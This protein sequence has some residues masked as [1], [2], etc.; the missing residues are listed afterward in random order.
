MKISSTFIREFFAL[1]NCK[2]VF[3]LALYYI[4]LVSILWISVVIYPCKLITKIKTIRMN[5][6][7]KSERKTCCFID[8]ECMVNLRKLLDSIKVNSEGWREGVRQGRDEE[9]EKD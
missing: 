5:W 9:G 6:N 1:E 7:A 8:N 3:P 4:H 2:A